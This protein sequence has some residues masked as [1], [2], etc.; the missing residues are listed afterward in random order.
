MGGPEPV[1]TRMIPAAATRI[2][3]NWGGRRPSPSQAQARREAMSGLKVTMS[4]EWAGE[5]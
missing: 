4:A 3:S 2:P 5:V 1:M